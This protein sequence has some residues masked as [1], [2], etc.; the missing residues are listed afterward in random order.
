MMDERPETAK[1]KRNI[2]LLVNG[3]R[4]EIDVEVHKTL[5]EILRVNLGLTGTKY[6]CGLGEC[7]A[8]TVLLDDKAIS[9]C[10]TLAVSADGKEITTIEGMSSKGKLHPIQEEFVKH[11]A[12]QCGYCTPGLVMT[13]KTLLQ[14]KPN[15]TEEEVREYIKGHLCRCSGYDKIVV[16]ILAAGKRLQENNVLCHQEN[17]R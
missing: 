9:S 13:A 7:G 16:A 10:L 3:K 1:K 17:S 11:G 8:C 6:G 4:Y 5:L 15:A 2:V 14:E 12:I